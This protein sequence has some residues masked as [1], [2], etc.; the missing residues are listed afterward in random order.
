MTDIIK[1]M[2]VLF[3]LIALS[4]S[5]IVPAFAVTAVASEKDI[6]IMVEN[7]IEM[8]YENK[9]IGGDNDLNK[10]MDADIV[11]LLTDKADTHQ[12]VTRLYQTNKENYS[13]QVKLKEKE[14]Y[15]D[16]LKLKFQVI[17]TYNY[18]NLQDVDTV[19]SEVVEILY[20]YEKALI[21]DLYSPLNYYD[22]AVRGENLNPP[23]KALEDNNQAFTMTSDIVSYQENLKNDIDRVY[24]EQLY[25]STN[26]AGTISPLRT[27]MLDSDAIVEYARD[28][29]DEDQP[30]SGDGIVPYYDFSE[31]SGAYDCTNFVSHALLAG[32]AN[33]YD[34]G[35][36]GISSTGWY[37]RNINNRSSSW[38]G[39]TSLYNF[40]V[41]NTHSNTAAG[42]SFIYTHNGAYWGIGDVMQFKASGASSYSH[43]TIITL[44]EYSSDGD[45]AYAYVTGRTADD[46]FNDNQSADEMFPNG[47]KRTI[48]VYNY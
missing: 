12:Y 15:G 13:V 4:F 17:S 31:I 19:V 25:V 18:V 45:R 48:Y 30:A 21:T 40:L 8:F 36:S 34:T 9:D 41:T 20:D 29:Y 16:Q 38:S 1:K 44:K 39:V 47:S 27:D 26:E 35:G 46:W 23:I 3:L 5:S 43:S 14:T 2:L 22:L 42:I 7:A 32:G 11:T 33:V 6:V 10:I 37:Y 28:N 24:D